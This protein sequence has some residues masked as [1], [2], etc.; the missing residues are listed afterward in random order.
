MKWC[1]PNIELVLNVLTYDKLVVISSN[2]ALLSTDP[3]VMNASICATEAI[4]LTT[5]LLIPG[6]N[7]GTP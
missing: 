6:L 1:I 2:E 7:P 5:R 3:N 4:N